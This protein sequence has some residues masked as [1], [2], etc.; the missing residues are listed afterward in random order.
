MH[1]AMQLHAL[2]AARRHTVTCTSTCTVL[3]QRHS[4]PRSAQP[5]KTDT[6]HRSR[7]LPHN[8]IAP[9]PNSQLTRQRSAATN[10]SVRERPWNEVAIS[11]KTDSISLHSFNKSTTPAP[12]PF[13]NHPQ[14]QPI[15]QQ[16]SGRQGLYAPRRD[17]I[18]FFHSLIAILLHIQSIQ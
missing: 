1:A 6:H 7:T 13:N 5:A 14:H 4:L 10:S 15:H 16:R 3:N 8:H 17:P 9:G 18:S 12:P 2:T 11:S